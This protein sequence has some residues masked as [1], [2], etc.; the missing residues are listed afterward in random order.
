MARPGFV[1]ALSGG[2]GGAKLA[3][4]LQSVLPAGA[5]RIVA[6]TGDD[7][8]HMGLHVSP[9]IDTLLY[10]LSDRDDR[11]RGWG[12]RGETWAFMSALGELGAETWFNLGDKD[13]AVHVVRTRELAS[14]RSLS[15]V[16]AHLAK[17]LGISSPLL[18]MSDNPVRTHVSTDEGWMAF[19]P[20]F[21]GRRAGPAV[22]DIR[23]DGAELA[24]PNPRVL[25]W[26]SEPGLEAIILC[27]SNPYLSIDPILA[28]PGLRDAVRRA[29]VPVVAV[30]PIIAGNSVKGPT[31]DLMHQ[32]GITPGIQAIATHYRGLI[33]ALVIDSLDELEVPG[34]D[35][36]PYTLSNTLMV[37]LEDRMRVAEAAISLARR[38]RGLRT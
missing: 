13:L 36:L 33:D 3:L 10:A 29:G 11:E 24:C 2:V 8:E 26:L 37:T 34:L 28:V 9:D 20:W 25:D 38:L 12:R 14:G 23:F 32:R 35:G 31:A 4:G 5:L 22:H 15:D 1:I 16:T 21:V 17:C 7:F 18:P 6:N 27:P 19:Q 30:S